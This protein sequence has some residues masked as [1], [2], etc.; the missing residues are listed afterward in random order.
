MARGRGSVRM[1]VL[2]LELDELEDAE[3]AVRRSAP[4]PMLVAAALPYVPGGGQ[5]MRGWLAR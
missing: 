2:G 1:V 3:A 5:G 4:A